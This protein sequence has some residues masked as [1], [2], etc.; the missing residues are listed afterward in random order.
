MR[1]KCRLGWH[2]YSQHVVKIAHGVKV[3]QDECE[4]GAYRNYRWTF[5][6]DHSPHAH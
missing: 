3:T 4:C 2:D 1:L 5:L 6:D